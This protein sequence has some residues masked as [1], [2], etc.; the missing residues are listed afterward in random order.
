[1]GLAHRACSHFPAS[2]HVHTNTF[3]FLFLLC[4]HRHIVNFGSVIVIW[5]RAES[6]EFS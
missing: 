3:A 6:S 4:S 1:M 2:L 5:Y